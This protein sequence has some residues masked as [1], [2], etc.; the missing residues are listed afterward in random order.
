ME[1]C[2]NTKGLL[3]IYLESIFQRIYQ[4]SLKALS[5]LTMIQSN[6]KNPY[7]VSII[8]MESILN[9]VPNV[10]ISAMNQYFFEDI[11]K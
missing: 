11:Y 4:Y 1:G 5:Y 6:Y 3:C 7:K 10:T 2:E 8:G 9:N